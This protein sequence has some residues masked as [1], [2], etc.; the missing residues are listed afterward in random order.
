MIIYRGDVLFDVAIMTHVII[1]TFCLRLMKMIEENESE[2][3]TS[4]LNHT[5]TNNITITRSHSSHLSHTSTRNT[6][7]TQTVTTHTTTREQM[8]SSVTVSNVSTAETAAHSGT[9]GAHS[10]VRQVC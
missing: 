7:T 10:V 4:R 5:G 3:D 2:R 6:V 8:P 1:F 9:Q